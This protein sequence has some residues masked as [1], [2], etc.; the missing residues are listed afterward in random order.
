MTAYFAGVQA[1]LRQA[2][3]ERVEAETRAQEE[4]KRRVLADELAGEAEARAIAERRRRQLTVGL[5]AS[6][7]ALAGLAGGSWMMGERSRAERRAAVAQALG[8]TRRLQTVALAAESDDSAQWAEA[9]AALERVQ[10]L[11][12]QG[13]DAAQMRQA[14]ELRESIGA[15]RDSAR[16]EAEWLA[17]LVDLRSTEANDLQGSMAEAGY[18]RV[19]REAGIDPD[20]MSLDAAAAGIRSRKPL[21][22]QALIAALDAWSA[23]RRTQRHDPAAARRL[24]AVARLADTDTWRDR[25]RATLDQPVGKDRLEKLRELAETARIEELPAVSLDLLGTFLLADGDPQ[26]AADLLRKAQ[27]THPRDAWLKYDLAL[28]L[29]KLR[30]TEEAIRYFMAARTIRPETSHELA[31]VLEN[32]GETDEAIAVFQDLSRLRPRNG[33]HLDCLGR[34]LQSR[35]RSK[36]AAAA[37]DA[38]IRIYRE[39]VA[40]DPQ[41]VLAHCGLGIALDSKNEHQEAVLELR[42]AVRLRPDVSLIH[43]ALG[44]ALHWQGQLDEAITEYREVIRLDPRLAD[45]HNSLGVALRQ[46]GKLNEAI[47]QYR[48]AIRLQ[49]DYADAHYNLGLALKD[50]GKVVEA[51]AAYREAIRLRPDYSVAHYNLGIALAGQGKWAEAIAEL[52]VA[53]QLQPDNDLA[54]NDLAWGL[55]VPSDRPAGEYAEALEHAR[56]AVALAPKNANHFNTLALA[57]YRSG[58]WIKSLSAAE[59]A[60]ALRN[61]GDAYDWF[62]LAL[63]H[64]QNGDREKARNWFGKAVAWTKA[65][66]PKNP[67]L[68]QF[69]KE[70]AGLLGQPGPDASSTA[71]P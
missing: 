15:G 47:A 26:A 55:A 12:A 7:L 63:A 23:L 46:Q 66:D 24:L 59:A 10:G 41:D 19:F 22:A 65:R 34:A 44:K 9:S 18:T 57:E 38:A 8:E 42:T 43:S 58:H 36:E 5:A 27:R 45:A 39:Q 6:I 68:L 30:R 40:Q 50:Q 60:M 3:L 53:I 28:A 71:S 31:H 54:Q 17:R 1:R 32:R 33:S 64:C 20:A 56:K 2:E 67:E 49:P 52:R 16:K 21:L 70:A 13:G 62:F 35:G 11:L 25:L 51:I 48:E 14:D 29:E 4:A 69:W 61:G 37:L